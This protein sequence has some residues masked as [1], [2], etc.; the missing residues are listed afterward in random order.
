VIVYANLCYRLI[1]AIKDKDKDEQKKVL[2]EMSRRTE[3]D[4]SPSGMLKA[5]ND[6][7]SFMRICQRCN[8]EF[9]VTDKNSARKYC[10]KSCSSVVASHARWKN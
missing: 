4:F 8:V 10:N 9:Y 2:R 7:K 1:Q 6:P 5:E 3:V